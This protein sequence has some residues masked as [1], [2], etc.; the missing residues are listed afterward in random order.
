M[1]LSL[2]VACVATMGE[3]AADAEQCVTQYLFIRSRMVKIVYQFIGERVF[4]FNKFLVQ[5]SNGRMHAHTHLVATRFLHKICVWTS[6]GG[7]SS[8]PVCQTRDSD[9]CDVQL[10]RHTHTNTH[11]H[12]QRGMVCEMSIEYLLLARTMS[13][14]IKLSFVLIP[15]FGL[16]DFYLCII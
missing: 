16:L 1:R 2:G 10:L 7:R 3:L 12:R 5:I 14:S 9:A 4:I 15:I 11:A 6:D 13:Y 8:T